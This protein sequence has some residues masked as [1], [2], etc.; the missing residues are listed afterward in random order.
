MPRRHPEMMKKK[1][2]QITQITQIFL[3]F[4]RVPSRVFAAYFHSS[5]NN[6]SIDCS[7]W[8]AIFYMRDCPWKKTL[9][10]FRFLFCP[11]FV[12]FF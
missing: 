12:T 7:K 6:A 8:N 9:K 5:H 11:F 1:K 2:P 3:F 4:L 10:G